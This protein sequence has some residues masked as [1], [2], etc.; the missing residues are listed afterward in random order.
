MIVTRFEKIILLKVSEP[1][2]THPFPQLKLGYG[3]QIP[4]RRREIVKHPVPPKKAKKQSD[5]EP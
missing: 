1:T 4:Q 5:A 3:K 2:I